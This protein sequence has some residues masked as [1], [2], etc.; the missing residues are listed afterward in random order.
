MFITMLAASASVVE[1]DAVR[2]SLRACV[3]AADSAE[4]L[5]RLCLRRCGGYGEDRHAHA[6]HVTGQALAPGPRQKEDAYFGFFRS[7]NAAHDITC[8][9]ADLVYLLFTRRKG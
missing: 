9:A 3:D 1:S 8:V 4:G 7:Q 5:K 2:E 6:M